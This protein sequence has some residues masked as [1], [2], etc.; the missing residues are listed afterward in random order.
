MLLPESHP[1]AR[2]IHVSVVDIAA[3]AH[4]TQYFACLPQLTWNGPANEA[5]RTFAGGFGAVTEAIAKAI[6]EYSGH[7]CW[8]TEKFAEKE[9]CGGAC[10]Y[11]EEEQCRSELG[12]DGD[13]KIHLLDLLG[14]LADDLVLL[15][16]PFILLLGQLDD[17]LVMLLRQQ[18]DGL[19]LLL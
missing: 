16:T 13:L 1:T 6:V 15:L 17:G 5:W 19:V 14:Q 3:S 10:K 9:A 11:E 18:A 8:G 4:C 2:L 12:L 7:G